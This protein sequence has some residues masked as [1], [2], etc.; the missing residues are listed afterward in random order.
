[1]KLLL[2][3]FTCLLLSTLVFGQSVAPSIIGKWR[4]PANKVQ[5]EIYK[6]GNVYEAKLIASVCECTIKMPFEQHKDENNPNKAL[7]NRSLKDL[8]ILTGM[9]YIKPGYYSRGKIYDAT[10]GKTY[11]ASIYLKMANTLV[12]RGYWG[13]ELFGK[14]LVFVRV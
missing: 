13:F 12:V 8:R 1:M 11:S 10:S 5:V 14:S 7:R 2:C 6:N 4:D 9:Q 3:V